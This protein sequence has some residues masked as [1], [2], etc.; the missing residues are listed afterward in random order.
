MLFDLDLQ[1]NGTSGQTDERAQIDGGDYN[2]HISLPPNGAFNYGG[3]G[4]FILPYCPSSSYRLIGTTDNSITREIPVVILDQTLGGN[5][6]EATTHADRVVSVIDNTAGINA[7]AQYRLISQPIFDNYG[8][9]NYVD[10]ILAFKWLVDNQITDGII[11]MSAS[12][13]VYEDDFS[14]PILN[15]MNDILE[16]NNLLLVSSAGNDGLTDGTTIFPGS[17]FFA[18]EITVAGTENCFTDS[19]SNTNANRELFEI[20]AEAKDVLL[21]LSHPPSGHHHHQQQAFGL[22]DGTSFGTPMVTGAL[23]QLATHYAT[24]DAQTLK[25]R[26]LDRADQVPALN[27]TVELGRVLNTTSATDFTQQMVG[28]SP[29]NPPTD[30][31]EFELANTAVNELMAYPNPFRQS[32]NVQIP[33]QVQGTAATLT[34]RDQLGR[35]WY[36]QR[37]SEIG[38]ELQLQSTEIGQL[39]A[40]MYYLQLEN[41]QHATTLLLNKQ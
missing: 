35:S 41:N 12:M 33:A 15:Y 21:P 10:I 7:L 38:N 29:N 30:S 27:T 22:V 2:Y 32:L 23:I 6:G 39:P 31:T 11:N 26:L 16:T 3:S 1:N 9:S 24:F 36:T 40:G 28:G 19:W 34:I 20:A 8:T 13:P 25:T 17:G 4:D 18:N 14:S 37:F 5:A